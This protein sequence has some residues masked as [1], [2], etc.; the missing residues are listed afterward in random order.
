[1]ADKEEVQ[2]PEEVVERP[3][4][5]MFGRM[6]NKYRSAKRMAV[7]D[8]KNKLYERHKITY[9]NQNRYKIVIDRVVLPSGKE[10]EE[11][12]LYELIDAAVVTVNPDITTELQGGISNLGE[13]NRDGK[14]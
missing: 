7:M 12:R 13:F 9:Q 6:L 4:G 11:L 3:A 8:A 1:M 5:N 10:V 2:V 14:G